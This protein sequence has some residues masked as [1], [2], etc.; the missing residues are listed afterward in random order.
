M[1]LFVEDPHALPSMQSG[2]RARERHV[3]RGHGSCG[4][5]PAA[6]ARWS[7]ASSDVSASGD[8]SVA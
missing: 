8:Y 1:S 7:V 2:D 5:C 3:D 6:V 4:L